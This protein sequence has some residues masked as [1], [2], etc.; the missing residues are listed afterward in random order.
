MFK[1]S[2]LAV[3]KYSDPIL[4]LTSLL[5]T[6]SFWIALL[7]YGTATLLWVYLLRTVPLSKA[8][9]FVALGFIAIPALAY[10]IFGE[11]LNISYMFGTG[12]IVFGIFLT[13]QS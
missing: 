7:L 2:A 11:K 5:R 6:A 8:Y 9:P 13:I 3:A 10:F 1:V 4:G 12:L